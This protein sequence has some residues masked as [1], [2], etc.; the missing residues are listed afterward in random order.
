MAPS[1]HVVADTD[2]R[3]TTTGNPLYDPLPGIERPYR[4]GPVPDPAVFNGW[5]GQT[6]SVL[7]ATT[8]AD[9]VAVLVNL[10][11]ASGAIIGPGP[12]LRLGDDRHPALIWALTVGET[13]AGRKGAATGTSK[14]LLA[15]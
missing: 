11:S 2:P 9:P 8:E 6:V 13:A 12:F 10:L 7:D 3:P 4:P 15:A 14:R 5:I 1:L